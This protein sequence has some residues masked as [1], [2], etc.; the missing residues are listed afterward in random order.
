MKEEHKSEIIKLVTF[1]IA[2]VLVFVVGNIVYQHMTEVVTWADVEKPEMY[3][4]TTSNLDTVVNIV[5]VLISIG[6]ILLILGSSYVCIST[7]VYSFKR[8]KFIKFFFT[9]AYYF[10]YGIL[11]IACLLPPVI[12]SYWLVDF[13]VVQGNTTGVYSTLRWLIIIIIIYFGIAGFGFIFKKTIVDLF[14]RKWKQR[15]DSIEW[16]KNMEDLPKTP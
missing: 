1:I 4:A 3:N 15:K 7:P 11:G 2:A 16:A 13:V 5:P 10:G 9:S 6:I 12:L 14:K 8:N